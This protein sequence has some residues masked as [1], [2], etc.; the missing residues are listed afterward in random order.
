MIALDAEI[1]DILKDSVNE[2]APMI[3]DKII[4][5][6]ER[7][8]RGDG[9]SMPDYSPVSVAVYG[10][11][12]GPM[13]L[14]DTGAFHRGITVKADEQGVEVT[15]NN[16]KTAMLELRYTDKIMAIQDRSFKELTPDIFDEKTG[17]RILKFLL[18][19]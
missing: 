10:K 15:N 18:T 17:E 6:L 1:V 7:G 14:N 9:V 3:E 11:R 13:T 16:W 5:Q 4:E 8:E 19:R 2:A 12:P